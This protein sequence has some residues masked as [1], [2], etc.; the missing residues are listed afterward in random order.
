MGLYIGIASEGEL[1]GSSSTSLTSC[2]GVP[3]CQ[4]ERL[5]TSESSSGMVMRDVMPLLSQMS[6]TQACN[7]FGGS[8]DIVVDA[9]LKPTNSSDQD[10]DFEELSLGHIGE[11]P[12]GQAIHFTSQIWNRPYEHTGGM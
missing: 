10:C 6:E 1:Q 11:L 5:V 8:A 3:W 9:Y 4:V 12:R 2:A 7:S